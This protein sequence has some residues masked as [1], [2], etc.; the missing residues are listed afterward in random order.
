[1]VKTEVIVIGS[2]IAALKTAL[3]V[4]KHKHVILITKSKIRHSNSYLAQGG[5]AAAISDRT[6]YPIIKKIRWRLVRVITRY[7][8]WKFVEEAPW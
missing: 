6:K 4:S 7:M 8:L 5:I 3:E 2:G 1:M